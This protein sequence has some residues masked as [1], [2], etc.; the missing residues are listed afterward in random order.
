[1]LGGVL[2]AA[3]GDG[4]IGVGAGVAVDE[5]GVA[6]G[7]VLATLEVARDVDLAA[8]GGAA[9][10]D[11][12]GFG[13]DVGRRF[14][15]GVDHLGAGV[16]VLA[17]IG[18]CDRDHLAAGAA[19]FHDHAGVFHG[20]ARADV[21][22]DPADFGVLHG[23]AALGD[24]VE[25]IAAP[26]LDGDVLDLGTFE[27]DEFHHGRVQGGGFEFRRGA[28]FHIHH[29]RAFIGDDEGAFELAE[30]FRVDAEVCLQRL[31]QLHALRD[32]D[33]RAA[34]EHGAVERGKLV[35]RGGDDLAEPRAEDFL[36]FLEAFRGVD[37]DH[38]LLG[39]LLLH[40]RVG[41]LRV[42]LCLDAGEEGSFLLGD[43]KSL[44]GFEHFRWHVVPRALRL[45]AIGKII[46]DLVEV[47][48]FQILG[49]PV[50]WHGFFKEHL[51]RLVTE[52]AHPFRVL[53]HV[54]DVID[55]LGGKAAAGIILVALGKGE[56]ALGAID[57]DRFVRLL[58]EHGGSVFVGHGMRNLRFEIQTCDSAQAR[59]ASLRKS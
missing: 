28:A 44:E 6:L 27:R 22:I 49:G 56:V 52:L 38:A 42:I 33:E 51:E 31:F 5:Q 19:A 9:F 26:V 55:R 39:E 34:G 35:V 57:V 41:G 58:V 8:V 3:H 54:A 46:T 21:A 43:A 7:V 11:G 1:M 45:L 17:G 13:N 59:A 47:D 30:V 50:R 12:N 36:V 20:E 32:V 48:V 25:D 14:I 4:G 24:E 10:A 37:E 40:V 2:V 53:F 18:E 15:R 16:L 29:F 23:E